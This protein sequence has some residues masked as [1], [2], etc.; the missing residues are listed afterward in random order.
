MKMLPL[1]AIAVGLSVLPARGA[2]PEWDKKKAADRLDKWSRWWME[3]EI[4]P[5]TTD[6]SGKAACLN[7]HTTAT[8][9]LARPVL[10]K[11]LGHKDIDPLDR[12]LKNVARRLVAWPTI[13]EMYTG[14]RVK[15]S[16]GP[17]AVLSSLMLAWNDGARGETAPTAATRRALEKLWE[18]QRENGGWGASRR[19]RGRKVEC[20]NSH[21]HGRR[22]SSAVLG[23]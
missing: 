11:V 15:Q 23:G 17:E 9:A 21:Y 22:E 13:G 4:A 2:E 10:G 8:Y 19:K 14:G 3:E 5:R 1:V 12:L 20:G 6:A 7:C 16:R 18:T